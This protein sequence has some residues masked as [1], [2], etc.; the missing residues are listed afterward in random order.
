MCQ[1]RALEGWGEYFAVHAVVATGKTVPRIGAM[2]NRIGN[3]RIQSD[4]RNP[5]TLGIVHDLRKEC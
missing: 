1:N 3:F 2:S 5:N 4:F